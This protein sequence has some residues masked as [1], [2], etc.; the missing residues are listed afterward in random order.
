MSL[1]TY[2]MSISRCSFRYFASMLC[3]VVVLSLWRPKWIALL[4]LASYVVAIKT[5]RRRIT[6]ASHTHTTTHRTHAAAAHATNDILYVEWQKGS[7]VAHP[8][9]FGCGRGGWCTCHASVRLT[10]R[11]VV[12][13]MSCTL[14]AKGA[15]V[16]V[17]L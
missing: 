7:G 3:R 2:N 13:S 10:V 1:L 12:C 5:P 6:H 14:C 15:L 17:L 4:A 16:C 9:M 11:R 8:H